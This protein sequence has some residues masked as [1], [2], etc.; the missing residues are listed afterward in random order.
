MPGFHFYVA[1]CKICKIYVIFCQFIRGY[2]HREQQKV[3]RT[4]LSGFYSVDFPF[5]K[6]LYTCEFLDDI[7]CLPQQNQKMLS[8]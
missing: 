6:C 4:S 3:F 8:V 5:K 2:H 1:A 7:Y